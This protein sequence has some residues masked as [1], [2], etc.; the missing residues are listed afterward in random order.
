MISIIILN[1][2]KYAEE[3]IKNKK[4]GNE[5]GKTIFLLAKYYNSSC[6]YTKPDI[7][8]RINDFMLNSY[9]KYNFS[10]W[11]QYINKIVTNAIKQPLYE[12]DGVWITEDELQI[13]STINNKM[14]ERLAFTILCLAKLSNLRNPLNNSWVNCKNIEI[15]KLAHINTSDFNKNLYFNQLKNMGL[16]QYAKKIDNLNLRILYINNNSKNILF[17][18]DFRELGYEYLLYKNENI[19]RCSNCN[20]LIRDSKN[21]SKKYCKKCSTYQPIQTKLVTC[22]DCGKIFKINAKNNMTNRCNECY[23]IYRKNY[24]KKI[25]RQ[26]RNSSK[27]NAVKN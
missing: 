21:H 18:N 2:K 9:P 1:E 16:I 5:P 3:I 12:I 15:F 6:Q 13:I 25:K 7:I 11:I 22:V 23:K 20:I 4:I 24:Y 10:D 27:I 14:L 17:I 8:S 19:I 26:Q